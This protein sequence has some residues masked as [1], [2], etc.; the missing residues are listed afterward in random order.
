[1][2]NRIIITVA[3]LMFAAAGLFGQQALIQD[4][5]GTVELKQA[6][7]AVWEKA[8]RGQAIAGNTVISTGF[9]STAHLAIGNSLLIVRPL[10]RLSLTELTRKQDTEKV[11]VN[12]ATGRV[13]AEVKAPTGLRTEFTVQT[14]TTTASVRGTVFEFDTINLTVI[15]GTV[16]L[17]GASNVA[18][19]VDTG[20]VSYTDERT[21][22]AAA[23]E[24]VYIAELK[25][26]LPFA[27]QV[28]GIKE[29]TAAPESLTELEARIEF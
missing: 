8:V 9:K 16:S 17:T 20:G 14:P 10:T 15:E 4:M 11:E 1:M 23:P 28:V 27:S 6:G 7:S 5:V 12:L 3:V 29:K 26:E 22:Q 24:A 13:R 2:R 25:P 18:V 21:G 19:L